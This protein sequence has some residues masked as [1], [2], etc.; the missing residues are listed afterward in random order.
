MV[1]DQNG[2]FAICTKMQPLQ[3]KQNW[4]QSRK[5]KYSKRIFDFVIF[6]DWHQNNS[7]AAKINVFV[8]LPWRNM[9]CCLLFVKAFVV[10]V[11]H[12]NERKLPQNQMKQCAI[13]TQHQIELSNFP[14]FFSLEEWN[15][16]EKKERSWKTHGRSWEVNGRSCEVCGGHGR[17]VRGPGRSVGG[18][19]R[20]LSVPGKSVGG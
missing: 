20:S 12:Y 18:H 3:L 15:F 2:G 10:Q 14:P 5:I 11:S 17:S 1:A 4:C 19:W 9:S 6:L 16:E 8:C 13:G 7:F